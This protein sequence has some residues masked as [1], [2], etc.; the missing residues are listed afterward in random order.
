MYSLHLPSRILMSSSWLRQSDLTS[1]YRIRNF[2]RKDHLFF[3]SCDCFSLSL[4]EPDHP[5]KTPSCPPSLWKDQGT[6]AGRTGGPPFTGG[7]LSPHQNC[8]LG[9]PTPSWVD[10]A[11]L[12]LRPHLQLDRCKSFHEGICL[13]PDMG[14]EKIGTFAEKCCGWEGLIHLDNGYVTWQSW[15]S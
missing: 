13:P 9:A 14:K 15:G 6:Q 11:E 5:R 8:S 4:W 3:S 10:M 1:F 2:K 7:E 12:I